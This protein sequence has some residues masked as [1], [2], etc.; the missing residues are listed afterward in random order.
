[1]MAGTTTSQ[2]DISFAADRICG[3]A[4]FGVCAIKVA[5]VD[6]QREFLGHI[7]VHAQTEFPG[8]LDPLA[9]LRA[10]APPLVDCVAALRKTLEILTDP[11][12]GPVVW[13]DDAGIALR[14]FFDDLERHAS[15]LGDTPIRDLSAVLSILI[16]G[17]QL[18]PKPRRPHP[19][20]RIIG[21]RE[22]RFEAADVTIL[23]GLNDGIWP[24][25]PDP[26]PWLS[27]PMYPLAGLPPPER[28]VGLSAHDFLQAI[29][30][31][32]VIVS[33]SLRADGSPTVASPS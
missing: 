33:R 26:G 28:T 6:S 20:V 2:P 8:A 31:G 16:Q 9:S 18:R 21:T 15:V 10:S 29:C 25:M 12:D 7:D 4:I 11:G 22:A 30:R 24:E 13:D 23:A 1:M 27:R 5:C 19:R 17:R 14:Q 32:R 3:C